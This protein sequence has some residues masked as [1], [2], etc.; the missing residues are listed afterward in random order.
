MSKLMVAVCD[1]DEGYRDRFVAYLV[2][3]R[4]KDMAVYVFST[5]EL[6][7]DSI[8]DM[9]F[10][11]AVFGR[12]FELA[13]EAAKERNIPILIL[14]DVMP[15]CVA[16]ST[17]YAQGE[18]RWCQEIF[19]YQPMEGILHEIQVLAGG[20][21]AAKSEAEI[22]G[23]RMEIIGIYSPNAHE[24]QMPFSIVLAE[25]LAEQRKVLYV[26]L[27]EHSGFLQLFQLTDEYDMGDVV[28]KLRSKRLR[29]ETFVKS[30]Y[31]LQG[32]YYIPP[33]DNPENL[34][35]FSLE[36]YLEFL[37][38]LE[39]QTDFET[40]ILDFGAGLE[41]FGAMMAQCTSIYCLTKSGYF[42]ECQMDHFMRYLL[43]E[44]GDADHQ[45]HIVNLP[46]SA[47]RIRA[48]G[49]VCRQLLWSDFGDHVRGYFS[50]GAV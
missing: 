2:E 11:V 19:R 29:P 40:V 8:Q 18:I 50:G 37:R 43:R 46:F 15:E 21:Y 9:V 33:F 28:L 4:S 17:E 20:S 7:L 6:F 13:K 36:D 22:T 31:E 30:V 25:F 14:S 5:L 38:F 23:S 10:D 34:H 39:E 32:M 27:M 44:T 1:T 41:H 47:R 16:E 42:Y 45:L 24:M 3:H 26:N 12:G 49:D 48:G 35:D